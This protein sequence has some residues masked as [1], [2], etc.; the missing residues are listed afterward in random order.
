MS[1]LLSFC[2]FGITSVIELWCR[3]IVSFWK[4]SSVMGSVSQRKR[5]GCM[6]SR[7]CHD[8]TFQSNTSV[9]SRARRKW[10]EIVTILWLSR[11]TV[12]STWQILWQNRHD[13]RYDDVSIIDLPPW[14]H[15]PNMRK[16]FTYQTEKKIH[17]FFFK[18]MICHV[19][20]SRLCYQWRIDD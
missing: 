7:L 18:N 13:F 5:D 14:N 8:Y 3:G 2:V 19:T 12:M 20:T 10:N 17:I 11:K 1:C 4:Q 15:E 6:T 9:T 16:H